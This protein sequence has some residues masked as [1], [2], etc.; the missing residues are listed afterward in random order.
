ME[1]IRKIKYLIFLICFCLCIEVKANE[2]NNYSY[3]GNKTVGGYVN[4]ASTSLFNI[5]DE[6]GNML[7]VYCMDY[8]NLINIGHSY[9]LMNVSDASFVDLTQAI[10]LRNIVS[11]SYP[12]IDIEKVRVQSGIE[13]L[14]IEEAIGGTQAAIWY[15]VNGYEFDMED[16]IKRLFDFYIS[17]PNVSGNPTDIIEIEVDYELYFEEGVRNLKV[18]ARNDV[19]YDFQFEID[20][21]IKSKYDISI[22]EN[23]NEVIF[24]NVPSD[25]TLDIRVES[26][27]N[28]LKDVYYF[29]PTGGRNCSQ[30]LIGITDG[31]IAVS[32]NIAIDILDSSYDVS[33]YKKD[34]LTFRNLKG[35]EFWLSNTKDFSG[36]V[37]EGITDNNGLIV[38]K[39]VYSGIWYLREKETL[40]GYK[41]L[42]DM[43]IEVKN[44]DVM[45]EVLNE[46][47]TKVEIHNPET[48]DN[49]LCFVGVFLLSGLIL[50]Y[51]IWKNRLSF[52]KTRLIH[53]IF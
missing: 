43:I 50:A 26:F 27:Q 53:T 18:V 44:E 20:D 30:S 51:I 12:Y 38:F 17:I 37:Y 19:L 42:D 1:N 32:K 39:D 15:V 23:D 6:K 11:N 46:P 4:N 33:I 48:N 9:S 52:T 22:I 5:L 47:L 7:P 2:S 49:I 31:K 28:V 25:I 24:K 40:E 13:N 45:V 29:F 14:T 8:N 36:L 34:S 41:K 21:K 3:L 16:N 10:K 35:V